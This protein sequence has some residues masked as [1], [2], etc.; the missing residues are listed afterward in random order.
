MRL[1]GAAGVAETSGMTPVES[2]VA[3][4]AVISAL[5]CGAPPSR[6]ICPTD[7]AKAFAAARGEDALGW[8]SHLREVRCA[9][10]S[11]AIAGRLVIYR[12][13]KVV[14]PQNFRGVYRLGATSADQRWGGAR[15]ALQRAL[16]P[17]AAPGEAA[18][19]VTTSRGPGNK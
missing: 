15:S 19:R 8:R 5:C 2:P 6:T 11:L 14:D 3:L 10:V 18:R 13:G 17:S 9:A 12:K 4:E 7:A 16:E 1:D